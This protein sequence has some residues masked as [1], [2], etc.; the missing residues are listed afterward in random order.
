MSLLTPHKLTGEASAEQ[1]QPPKNR[2]R[3]AVA[4]GAGAALVGTVA[5]FVVTNLSGPKPPTEAPT[6][7]G[8]D[9]R[10]SGAV[11]EVPGLPAHTTA[12]VAPSAEV[13][14]QPAAPAV[15]YCVS[16]GKVAA[17]LAGTSV[18]AAKCSSDPG[19]GIVTEIE[20]QSSDGQFITV[21]VIDAKVAG[22]QTQHIGDTYSGF[23]GLPDFRHLK[24]V[25]G[26][27]VRDQYGRVH[28]AGYNDGHDGGGTPT[29]GEIGVEPGPDP[30]Q[31]ILVSVQADGLP[32]DDMRAA[33]EA[34]AKAVATK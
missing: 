3:K 6:G 13:H 32:G 24:T 11:T 16:L 14:T 21:A 1:Q 31:Y 29:K 20:V 5:G 15:D 4:V 28:S 10:G 7:P 26:F 33:L 22:P 23:G 30:D 18:T 34:S 12:A 27:S 19:R 8:A 25:Y 9:D 17:K 2:R